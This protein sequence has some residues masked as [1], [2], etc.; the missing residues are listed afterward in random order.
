MY[1]YDTDVNELKV[2]P[3]FVE[4]ATTMLYRLYPFV[5]KLQEV[6]LP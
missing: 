2:M 1:E 4:Y 5:A 3:P 6:V